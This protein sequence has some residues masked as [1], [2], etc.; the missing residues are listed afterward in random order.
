MRDAKYQ[1]LQEPTRRIAYVPY[2]QFPEFTAGHTLVAEIRTARAS[3]ET[4]RELRDAAR[5]ASPATPIGIELMEAR[6]RDSHAVTS[7][8]LTEVI[9]K[10]GIRFATNGSGT[11]TA[12]NQLAACG[13]WTDAVLL[14]LRLGLPQW[15]LMRLVYE[16]GEWH[17]FLSRQPQFPSGF[18]E[19]AEAA[20]EV[21]PLAVLI[22]VIQARTTV[23]SATTSVP[24][25]GAL[26]SCTAC[27]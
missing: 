2:R 15:K 8:L 10:A 19:G 4:I 9:A 12:F 18:D 27:R 25:V 11:R 24:Q 16:D 26:P 3:G 21:L 14:L 5:A 23:A 7:A 6:V 17:C 1:R 13:A 20:H 22:A